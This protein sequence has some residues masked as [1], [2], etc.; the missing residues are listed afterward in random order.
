MPLTKGPTK[1]TDPAIMKA[2]QEEAKRAQAQTMLLVKEA[3]A[4]LDKDLQ[5]RMIISTREGTAAY[6]GKHLRDAMK[7]VGAT[8]AFDQK[9]LGVHKQL[10]SA[11]G[12][13]K[14][15]AARC[16]AL[17]S[18]IEALK[19]NT[20]SNADIAALKKEIAALKK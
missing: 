13:V 10:E 18:E 15:L 20:A 7:E 4:K 14:V 17:S 2:M 6:L 1:A 16:A 5:E 9:L 3:M 11:E 19:K 12:A 8:V